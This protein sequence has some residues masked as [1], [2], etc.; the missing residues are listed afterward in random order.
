M[1]GDDSAVPSPTPTP[2]SSSTPLCDSTP[3]TS[4]TKSDEEC[5]NMDALIQM[6]L[7]KLHTESNQEQQC[8]LKEKEISAKLKAEE[9]FCQE[10]HNQHDQEGAVNL[11]HFAAI[12]Q[13]KQRIEQ[14]NEKLKKQ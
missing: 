1:H 10:V 3:N 4:N 7:D 9:M 6:E 5:K 11:E 14:E 8:V 13:E 12:A 2:V